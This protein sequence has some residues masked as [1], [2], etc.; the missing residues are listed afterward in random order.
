[1]VN[2]HV[3][4]VLLHRWAGSTGSVEWLGA[5]A[6][7]EIGVATNRH[8]ARGTSGE[9]V[10]SNVVAVVRRGAV[11]SHARLV[12][13]G[14][15]GGGNGAAV[16]RK[17]VVVRV[18]GLPVDGLHA[19]LKLGRGPELPFADNGPNEGDTTNAAGDSSDDSQA[20]FAGFGKGAGILRRRDGGVFS[21]G[22]SHSARNL[23]LNDSLGAINRGDG[24][25]GIVVLS[26][27]LLLLLLGGLGN[28]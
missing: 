12:A 2:R 22:T 18:R 19:V 20:D 15:E 24:L 4:A 3:A 13:S 28:A 23:D 1:M 8:Q 10:I 21:V 9:V 26:L 14:V 25:L 11:A 27:R 6:A 16:R 7:V 5:W 17:T